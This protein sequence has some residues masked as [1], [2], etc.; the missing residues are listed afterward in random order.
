MK[1][2]A[3]RLVVPPIPLEPLRFGKPKRLR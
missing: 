1:I 3:A 2:G